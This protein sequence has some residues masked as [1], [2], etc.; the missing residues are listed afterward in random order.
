VTL[1]QQ[2]FSSFSF[3]LSTKEGVRSSGVAEWG[4]GILGVFY[5]KEGG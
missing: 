1:Y 4:I 3:K 5:R 2:D